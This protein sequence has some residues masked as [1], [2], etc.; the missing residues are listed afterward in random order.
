[1]ASKVAKVPREEDEYPNPRHGKSPGQEH[2]QEDLVA[3]AVK[4]RLKDTRPSVRE[5]W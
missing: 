5:I 3:R 1:M 2:P 4:V